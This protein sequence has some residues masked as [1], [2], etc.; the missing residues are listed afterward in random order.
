M[1]FQACAGW[2]HRVEMQQVLFHPLPQIKTNQAHVAGIQPGVAD[3]S[4]KSKK[5]KIRKVR[6]A[7][8][9]Y[10]CQY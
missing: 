9:V 2:R 8:K 5:S 7:R 3:D 4:Q 6:K 10:F 1:S